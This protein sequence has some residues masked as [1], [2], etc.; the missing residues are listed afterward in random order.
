[1]DLQGRRYRR[2]DRHIHNTIQLPCSA[3][4]GVCGNSD[5]ERDLVGRSSTC[6]NCHTGRHAGRCTH[7]RCYLGRTC[8][9]DNIADLGSCRHLAVLV[10]RKGDVFIGQE[11]RGSVFACTARCTVRNLVYG[12]RVPDGVVARGDPQCRA[13]PDPDRMCG[14]YDEGG[15]GDGCIV[16]GCRIIRPCTGAVFVLPLSHGHILQ[17]GRQ[18]DLCR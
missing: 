10:R 17:V 16:T 11:N 3:Q 9:G 7:G 15:A 6:R 12:G 5:R 4:C 14:L 1:M 13:F 8:I 2:S 18:R